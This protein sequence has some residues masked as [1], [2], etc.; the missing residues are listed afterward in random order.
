MALVSAPYG[1]KPVNP[2][3]QTLRPISMVDGI[4]S[5]YNTAIYQYSPVILATSGTVT[6]GTTAADIYGV[7]EGC[8]YTT[9]DGQRVQSNQW[10]ANTSYVAGSMIVYLFTDPYITYLIQSSAT[11][12]QSAIGDEAD[13]VN[14]GTGNSTTGLSSAQIG[15]LVGAGNQ[16]QLRIINLYQ[17]PNNAWG[18]TY[19]DV[20]VQIARHQTVSNKVAV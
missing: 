13:F 19:V 3:G 7:F 4:A 2:T 11:L 20:M 12:A 17:T 18:D 15:T 6:V 9:T 16:G 5:G 10:V 8:E 1:L 14:P